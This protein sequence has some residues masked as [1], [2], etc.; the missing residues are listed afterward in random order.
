MPVKAMEAHRVVRRRG[1]H[2][3]QTIGSQMAVRLP[4]LRAGRPLPPG[5]FMLQRLSR[6][7]G[8]GAARRIRS[9]EKSKDLIGNRNR[10]ILA[11]SIVPQLTTLP[12]A[13]LNCLHINLNRVK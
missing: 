8:L 9:I 11:C 10:V 12:R 7:Q 6:P 13:P 4:A 3:F 5:I 1:S 2:V